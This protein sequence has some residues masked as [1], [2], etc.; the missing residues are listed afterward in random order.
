MKKALILSLL[1]LALSPL[2]SMAWGGKGH[3]MVAE[4]AFKY[5]DKETKKIVL[6]YLDGMTIQEASNWMD[7]IKKDKAYDFMKPFHYVNFEKNE[8]V[9]DNCC[10]NI[11][12]TLNST[13]KDLK[14]H[15]SFTKAEVKIKLCYL[16]HLIGDLH[17]PLHIGY[18]SDKGG[19]SFQVAFNRKGTNLHSLF[20]SGIIKYKKLKLRQCMRETSYGKKEIDA[21]QK[22]DVVNWSID[23][24][25]YL[26]TIYNVNDHK[27]DE[28]YVNTHLPT[29]KKQIH[30]AGIR[31]AGVLKEA[32]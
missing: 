4:I 2:Q 28:A 27:I 10:D 17:Q 24:R 7:D 11:I 5:L 19:N 14:N 23:S 21:I 30:L 12:A 15:K 20:D 6:Q 13:I 18:G 8:M 9:K 26:D 29:I 22:I 32:F 16:F 31:L 25:K 1:F 3:A